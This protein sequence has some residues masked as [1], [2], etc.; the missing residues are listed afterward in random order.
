MLLPLFLIY[1]L[2]FCCKIVCTVKI[3]MMMIK[4]IIIQIREKSVGTT[5]LHYNMKKREHCFSILKA[6]ERKKPDEKSFRYAKAMF[7]LFCAIII[8]IFIQD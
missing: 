4:I 1:I 5:E 7:P 6:L 8:Q 3:T 2:K